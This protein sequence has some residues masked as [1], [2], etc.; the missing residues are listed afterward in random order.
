MTGSAMFNPNSKGDVTV[1]YLQNYKQPFAKAND[2]SW[3]N[4]EWWTPAVWNQN[5]ASFNAKNNTTVTGMQYKAAEGFTLAF[6]NGW[7][8]EAYTN[9]KIWQVATLSPGK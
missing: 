8:K 5:K 1:L 2:E 3:K 7:E 9:G 6:Q 4:G